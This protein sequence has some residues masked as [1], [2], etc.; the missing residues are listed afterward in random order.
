M[1]QTPTYIN[2]IKNQVEKIQSVWKFDVYW[3]QLIQPFWHPQTDR[4]EHAEEI[5]LYTVSWLVGWLV[6]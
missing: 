4:N 6:G 5:Y 3:S 1:A 2:L